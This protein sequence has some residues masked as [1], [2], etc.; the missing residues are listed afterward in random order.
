MCNLAH[1][2]S[3]HKLLLSCMPH[4]VARTRHRLLYDRHLADQYRDRMVYWKIRRNSRVH[5]SMRCSLYWTAWTRRSSLGLEVRS[6]NRGSLLPSTGLAYG[7]H[8]TAAIT[9]GHAVHVF[10]SHSDI[11]QAGSN[12]CGYV[13]TSADSIERYRVQDATMRSGF[14]SMYSYITYPRS[15]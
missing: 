6:S 12:N 5:G 15:V 14:S 11:T 8:I 9:Q 4:V 13:S 10:A 1:G 3:C 2:T 7:L